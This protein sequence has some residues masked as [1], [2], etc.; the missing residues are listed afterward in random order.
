V[1]DRARSRGALKA[2]IKERFTHAQ[3]F[4]TSFEAVADGKVENKWV[5]PKISWVSENELK[6]MAPTEMVKFIAKPP[7]PAVVQEEQAAFVVRRSKTVEDLKAE[8]SVEW[9][10]M[11]KALGYEAYEEIDW[12][13]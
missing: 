8:Y 12:R 1:Q 10:V 13:T 4:W 9:L 3:A 6:R 11:R 5:V 2:G 7:K